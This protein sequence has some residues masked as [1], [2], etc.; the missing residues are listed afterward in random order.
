MCTKVVPLFFLIVYILYINIWFISLNR[1]RD[2]RIAKNLDTRKR[3]LI[4]VGVI[5]NIKFH[6]IP[7]ISSRATFATKF[8]SHAH[9][10]TDRH[11]PKIVKSY[12]GHPKMCKSIKNWKSK[13]C[14]TPI[15]SFIYIEESK[16]KVRRRWIS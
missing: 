11:F 6:K 7:F 13:I 10:H 14:T 16:K 4:Y 15:F 3:T 8:L 12:S 9:R 2:L 5:L 1:S